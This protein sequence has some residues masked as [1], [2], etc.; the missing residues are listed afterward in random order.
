[1]SRCDERAQISGRTIVVQSL[2]LRLP[3]CKHSLFL[4]ARKFA[5]LR[6]GLHS[7]RL[8]RICIIPAILLVSGARLAAQPTISEQI[9]SLLFDRRDRGGNS[10]PLMVDPPLWADTRYLLEGDSRTRM[11]ALSDE[12]LAQDLGRAVPDPRER[13]LL[14][15]AL[16]Q[17]F[18]WTLRDDSFDREARVALRKKLA[19]VISRLAL[20]KAQ[21]E[22]L[23]TNLAPG[24]NADAPPNLTDERQGWIALGIPGSTPVAEA[25]LKQFGGRSAFGVFIRHPD[26]PQAALAYLRRLAER[27]IPQPR[28]DRPADSS[29]RMPRRSSP[30]ARNSRCSGG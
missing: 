1:M 10:F 4:R 12:L 13:A 24:D 17:V 19:A 3:R 9:R 18:D 15:H 22:S 26:G 25:H 20:T 2:S 7:H 30:P 14:Q 23:P 28:S 6:M 8:R 29:R 21:I 16:W 5:H 11:L 27:P